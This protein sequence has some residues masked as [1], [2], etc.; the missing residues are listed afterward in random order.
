MPHSLVEKS[1]IFSLTVPYWEMPDLKSM[2]NDRKTAY[3][4]DLKELNISPNEVL[5]REQLFF[6]ELSPAC[7]SGISLDGQCAVDNGELT[8]DSE[9]PTVNCQLSP[10]LGL[11]EKVNK[12]CFERSIGKFIIFK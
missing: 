6:L 5:A 10:Y 2:R 11:A 1:C 9:E 8:V 4:P 7:K 3:L 12:R